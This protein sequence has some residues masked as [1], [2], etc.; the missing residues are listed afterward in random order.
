MRMLA[1]PA[2]ETPVEVGEESIRARVRA[3]FE[4]TP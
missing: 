1:A 2:P 3:V 4:L